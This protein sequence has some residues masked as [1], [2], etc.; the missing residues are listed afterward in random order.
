MATLGEDAI[1]DIARQIR[2]QAT[3]DAY[4]DQACNG[5]QGLRA[6][7]EELL[8]AH[9]AADSRLDNPLLPPTLEHAE[10]LA[11]EKPGAQIGPYRLLQQLGEGG[12]GIVYLAERQH[13]V[14]QR[15][16]LK[17]IK[18]GM[19]SKNFV[20]RF[21]AERQA[22]AMMDHPNI[23]KVLDA[24][25]TD[26]GRPYFAMELVKG[27]AI[28]E[29]CDENRLTTRERLQLFV[30]VCQAVHHAH[31]K[32]V[33]HRD[34]KPSNVLVALYD[35]RPVPKVIDFGVAKATN[36]PLTE[37]TLFT[38]VGSILGTWEYMSPE[39]AVMNQLDVDTRTDVY[40]LG[41]LLY[42]LLTGET[43]LDRQQ[44]RAAQLMETL[45]M[46]REDEPQK[47]S[48]RISSLGERATLAATYRQ[49]RPDSL[50][51]EIR[52]DLDWISM[53]A[54]AK[55]RSRRY[56]SA[57][58]LAEDVERFLRN[59][60]IDARPPSAWYQFRKFYHRNKLLASSVI[61]IV[62]ALSLG[63]TAASIGVGV[64][65]T[66]S[67]EAYRILHELWQVLADR[68]LDAAF[69]G[70]L[71]DAWSAIE[72][73]ETAE[74]PRELTKTLRGV[75]LFIN[76]EN[77]EAIT[78]LEDAIAENPNGVSALSA[79]SWVYHYSG[80]P[81]RH[82]ECQQRLRSVEGAHPGQRTIYEKFFL[83]LERF[84]DGSERQLRN[85][86]DLAN[87]IIQE[88][89]DWGASY[90]LRGD[91]HTALGFETKSLEQF[92]LAIR[93]YDVA[94]ARL[95]DSPM[96]VASELYALNGMIDLAA[97]SNGDYQTWLQRAHEVAAKV[98]T[99][100]PGTLAIEN[101]AALH[102]R[103]GDRNIAAELEREVVRRAEEG[104]I[105]WTTSHAEYDKTEIPLDSWRKDKSFA[106]KQMCLA[107]TLAASYPTIA[108]REECRE[109][110][111]AL[112]A[113][114]PAPAYYAILLDVAMLLGDFDLRDRIITQANESHGLDVDFAWYKRVV[115]YHN[116]EISD[117]ALLEMA[118][119]LVNW[120]S[121]AYYSIA[122]RALAE[123]R[124]ARAE[125]Y[126][127]KTVQTGSVG[128]WTYH[129]AK[130]FLKKRRADPSWP[131]A[132]GNPT[133][134]RAGEET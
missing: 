27:T 41:V 62:A 69:S 120:Q 47:P 85:N 125:E 81:G 121:I 74:A 131:S 40:S 119:P 51:T 94:G 111:S 8:A 13:P 82:E 115:Q 37:K 79:L 92:V 89:G 73:A 21:E 43:P 86:L 88:K 133:G 5:N 20:A 48:T 11:R 25:C 130:V 14:K 80:Q 123:R 132:T 18:Q 39:Q 3:R 72:K 129:N 126:L 35:H 102:Y 77:A 116:G 114:R 56:D 29:F 23:A 117:E 91:I 15:V 12:M 24:G 68:A 22:L 19:D 98:T 134:L 46:I 104:V 49:T 52:G 122:M 90:V 10:P 128:Y 45:R 76:G 67:R 101:A 44:L 9:D 16:A 103:H 58:Q 70:D 32:G 95:P 93:D 99:E 55:E 108:E 106:E 84:V 4:L 78:T 7:V 34:I 30:Q 1:F 57:S 61:T 87:T 59:E 38:E 17:I 26:S 33:I 65:I 63:L 113:G 96:I 60:P 83:C 54:L 100:F 107:V 6:R 110:V 118:E 28:S 105:I 97:A 124:F 42:E 127:E 109:I 36:Q 71:Q 50:A 2:S 66:S 53:K 112:L 31:Q 75:A 64:A